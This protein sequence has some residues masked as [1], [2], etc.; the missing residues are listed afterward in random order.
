MLRCVSKQ[1][2]FWY[3]FWSANRTTATI[4]FFFIGIGSEYVRTTITS[5]IS[6]T[7]NQRLIIVSRSTLLSLPKL[8]FFLISIIY[9]LFSIQFK[10]NNFLFFSLK[11]TR[12]FNLFLIAIFITINAISLQD[13]YDLGPRQLP[14]HLL[15]LLARFLGKIVE[16][17]WFLR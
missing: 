1:L 13:V 3:H 16:I 9:S 17:D 7:A 10:K 11:F 14:L 4:Y 8:V 15:L 5:I 6:R 2:Y 12:N